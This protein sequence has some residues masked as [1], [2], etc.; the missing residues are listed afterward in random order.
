M[1]HTVRRRFWIEV[2]LA[3]TC[4]AVFAATVLAP[5]WIEQVFG[6]EPDGGSGALEVAILAALLCSTLVTCCMARGEWRRAATT[7][8]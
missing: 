2:S 4:L 8:S 6:V 1:I 3:G 5:R 7:G